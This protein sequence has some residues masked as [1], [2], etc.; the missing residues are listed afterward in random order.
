M[1]RNN[2]AAAAV[3]A[4]CL[5]LAGCCARQ[6]SFVP[7]RERQFRTET[8]KLPLDEDSRRKL[9]LY[10]SAGGDNDKVG[11]TQADPQAE[12]RY[13]PLLAMLADDTHLALEDLTTKRT[14]QSWFQGDVIREVIDAREESSPAIDPAAVSDGRF[15]WV[16]YPHNKRLESVMVMLPPVGR[17]PGQ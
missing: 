10:L 12:K 8:F 3:A 13:R 14:F 1:R 6:V 2:A 5:T 11:N 9:L 7:V 16:F 4:V 17:R 15:W